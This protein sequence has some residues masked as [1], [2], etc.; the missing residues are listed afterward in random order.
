MSVSQ[1]LTVTGLK[2]VLHKYWL[3]IGKESFYHIPPK[4]TEILP[5][6]GDIGKS[7]GL[8]L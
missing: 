2:E 1:C 6:F 8:L 5:A 4:Y 3:I 7:K